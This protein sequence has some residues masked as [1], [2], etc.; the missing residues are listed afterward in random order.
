MTTRTRLTMTLVLVV[1]AVLVVFAPTSRDFTDKHLIVLTQSG[2][3]NVDQL[4]AIRDIQSEA[5]TRSMTYRKY[6]P[7]QEAGRAIL[8]RLDNSTPLPVIVIFDLKSQQVLLV[9]PVPDSVEG[10][11]KI[12][13]PVPDGKPQRTIP[14]PRRKSGRHGLGSE[15]LQQSAWCS[16]P[17]ELAA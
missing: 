1:A 6:D 10:L 13:G 8:G 9:E 15:G 12:L 11:R 3:L 7:D 14:P 16:I 5:D 4:L 2:D 17:G